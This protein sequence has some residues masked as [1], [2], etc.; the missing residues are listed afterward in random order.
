MSLRKRAADGVA[1]LIGI[2]SVL[3]GV[4][5]LAAPKTVAQVAGTAEFGGRLARHGYYRLLGLRDLVIGIG[6]LA[7]LPRGQQG[8]WL[9]LRAASDAVDAATI[10]PP[11]VRSGK[12]LRVATGIALP[13]GSAAGS[14]LARRLLA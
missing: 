9:A 13:L 6:I 2:A 4:A 5:A 11:A 10:G 12:P 1:R 7:G 8:P 14:L 3:I